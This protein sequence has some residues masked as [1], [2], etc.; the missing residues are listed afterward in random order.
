M[1]QPVFDSFIKPAD[2]NVYYQNLGK[3]KSNKILLFINYSVGD[4]ILFF[5]MVCIGTVSPFDRCRQEE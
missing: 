2:V 4:N 3:I 1:E 5:K